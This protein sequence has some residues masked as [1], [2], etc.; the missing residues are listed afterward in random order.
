MSVIFASLMAALLLDGS[1]GQA[2]MPATSADLPTYAQLGLRWTRPP[3][4]R[5]LIRHHRVSARGYPD[6]GWAEVGC[7]PDDRGRLDCVVLNESPEGRDFGR[8]ALRVMGPVR[9]AS[10]DG[11]SPAGKTF[12]FRVRFGRWGASEM[13]DSA[14][15]LDQNLRWTVF[16]DTTS[17]NMAGVARYEAATAT[18]DCVARGDGGLDCRHVG[19]PEDN[20]GLVRAATR[21][22]ENARVRRTDDRPLEGSPLRWTFRLTR[23]SP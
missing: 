7:T 11:T 13:P 9:V 5:D 17:W 14:H 2:P 15:P 21:G 20:E 23:M 19:G 6:R 3:S 22:L 16:P 4:V 12:G 18:F 8:A 1:E 10:I